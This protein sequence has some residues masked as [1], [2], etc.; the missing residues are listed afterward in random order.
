MKLTRSSN[1][2]PERA[3]EVVEGRSAHP[4]LK[5][6]L[7]RLPSFPKSLPWTGR[8]SEVVEGGISSFQVIHE[9][10]SKSDPMIYHLADLESPAETLE[11]RCKKKQRRWWEKKDKTHCCR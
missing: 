9:A 6:P 7:P 4:A 2:R 5:H 3:Q 8:R 10:L 1:A 11:M